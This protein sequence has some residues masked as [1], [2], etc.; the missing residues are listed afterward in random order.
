[1]KEPLYALRPVRR[2]AV[3]CL[4]VGVDDAEFLDR[5]ERLAEVPYSAVLLS[6]GTLDCSRYSIAVSDPFMVF[7]SKGQTC[8]VRSSYGTSTVFGEPLDILEK[9]CRSLVPYYGLGGMPFAGGAVGYLAYDLKNR[10]EELP[11]TAVDDTHLPDILMFWPLTVLIHDRRTG[12][13]T[14]INLDP[15]GHS[16]LQD[17][18]CVLQPS[19]PELPGAAHNDRSGLDRSARSPMAVGVGSVHMYTADGCSGRSAMIPISEVRSDNT[20]SRQEKNSN[21]SNTV[22]RVEKCGRSHPLLARPIKGG[23]AR[24]VSPGGRG[25]G[26]GGPAYF[27][28]PPDF[29]ERDHDVPGVDVGSLRSTFSREGYLDAVEKIRTYIRNGDVYQVNLSQRFEFPFAGDPFD[30]WKGLFQRNPAPFFAF[31]NAGDHQVLSTSMERFLLRKG[32]QVETR[33]IKGTRKRGATAAEDEE[34]RDELANSPKD[35][36]ELSMIVDLLRNDL[37]RVCQ[38]RSVRVTEHKRLEAYENVYHLV[39][40][41]LGTLRPNVSHLDLIRATFPGGSITG[42]P[43]IRAMEIIDELEPVARHVYTGCIG[44]LGWHDNL[45]MNI[46]IRTAVIH[47]GRGLLSVGGGVVYDSDPAD[48]YDETLHKGRTFLRLFGHPG[49][50]PS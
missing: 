12:I 15:A 11:Q 16:L 44:Y 45:D 36:A 23:E 47:R 31:I 32:S 14:Q 18:T 22:S 37:G 28:D 4:A 19:K 27:E 2:R 42:C 38:P 40:I 39:S 20:S 50:I 8:E 13:L 3:E 21:P 43:K 48:E 49:E 10:T 5:V 7:T 35:D 17:P 41:V 25:K 46:A 1:M 29:R 9:L 33:P 30:L 6:G 24:T 26:E 34:L